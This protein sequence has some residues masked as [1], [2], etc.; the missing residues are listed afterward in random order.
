M[1]KRVSV[2]DLKLK[3]FPDV[4]KSL[5]KIAHPDADISM[6][7][8]GSNKKYWWTCDYCEKDYERCVNSRCSQNT[9]SACQECMLLKR[10]Q[11]NFERLGWRSRLDDPKR[12][13]GEKRTVPEP[14]PD[15]FE[16]EEWKDLPADLLLSR[17]QIS[18]MGSLKNKTTG[19]I[20]QANPGCSGYIARPI[21]NDAGQRKHHCYH[22]LV[23]RAFLP[24]PLDLPTVNH[25][26]TKRSD[27]R[28]ANLEWSSH[29]EQGY[30]E[31]KTERKLNGGCSI[32]IR[33]L[34]KEGNI[35]KEWPS[36]FEVERTLGIQRKNICKCLK[37]ERKTCGGFLWEYMPAEKIN[38]KEIWKP[39]IFEKEG[40][41]ETIV[42][43][44]GRV[45]RDHR[46]SPGTLRE[47]GY[48]DVKILNE[49]TRKAHS[50]QVHRL[51]ALAFLPNPD[52]LPYVNHKNSVRNDNRLGNLEWISASGNVRHY[53]DSQIGRANKTK[54]QATPI[55]K[56]VLQI[57]KDTKEV[58][59]QFAS[60]I[61]AE[62]QTG[63]ALSCIS[64][65]CN[66]K[67]NRETAGGFMWG[68]ASKN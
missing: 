9:S 31:N 1:S 36:A 21:I 17:Y 39:V 60:I 19:Y 6:I 5:S 59:A 68:F 18:S 40:F 49:I 67:K 41:R 61:E 58:I 27:N 55:C 13:S 50:F 66:G 20:S 11:T 8:A 52:N 65:C 29:S 7:Q 43:N 23:A 53:F 46:N 14:T 16:N 51:I 64:H 22:I 25:I 56:S 12:I 62:R 4:A 47:N 2:K 10:T 54:R 63:I 57:D 26:N 30:A 33:Q 38:E 32:P 3:D 28:L 42:S 48:C 44:L 35:L 37:G 15:D 45:K 34:D 24:N